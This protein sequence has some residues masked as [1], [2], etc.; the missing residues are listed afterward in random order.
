MKG[1]LSSSHSKV[2]R[3]F[4]GLTL[5]AVGLVSTAPTAAGQTT[6]SSCSINIYMYDSYGDGW[7]GNQLL[8]YQGD[9]LIDAVDCSGSYSEATVYIQDGYV[10]LAWTPGSWAEECRFII[11][12]NEN[13]ICQRVTRERCRR[14]MEGYQQADGTHIKGYV[15]NTLRYID[16]SKEQNRPQFNNF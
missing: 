1:L 4:F 13:D 10:D 7:N 16:L 12:N 2:F 8:L 9:S 14:I 15:G 11:T 3:L 6:S 5:T